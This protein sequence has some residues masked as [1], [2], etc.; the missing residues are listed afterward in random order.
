MPS[1][2]TSRRSRSKMLRRRSRGWGTRSRHCCAR[3]SEI[4]RVKSPGG[5]S[6]ARALRARRASDAPGS[7]P[8][9]LP[10]RAAWR[11][12]VPASRELRRVDRDAPRPG[13]L[14]LRQPEH[15]HAVLHLRLDPVAVDHLAEREAAVVAAD[16]V[17]DVERLQ[18]VVLAG[19]HAALDRELVALQADID[20]VG[21]HARHVGDQHQLVLG[22]EDVHRRLEEGARPR[23]LV[24]ALDLLLRLRLELVGSHG[25]ILLVVHAA[26]ICTRRGRAS[27]A[28]GRRTVSTPSRYSA[29]ASSLAR[30]PGMRTTRRNWPAPRSRR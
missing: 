23:R 26:S 7:T 20:P 29:L 4:I 15:E 2:T 3:L 21:R 17:L 9:R 27:L 1:R 19:A 25:L 22:L 18:A 5:P 10:P 13:A 11:L 28:F 8:A 6:S 24:A 30:R 12:S 14:C 16:P